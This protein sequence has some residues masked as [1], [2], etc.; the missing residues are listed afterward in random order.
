MGSNWIG[1]NRV[2]TRSGADDAISRRRVGNGSAADMD[3]SERDVPAGCRR[4]QICVGWF[5]M[6][7]SSPL[8]LFS[9]S[10][11]VLSLLAQNLTHNV[12]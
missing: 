10:D 2:E 7:L 5:H 6:I 12:I 9:I 4:H 1:N 11:R 8:A 3:R